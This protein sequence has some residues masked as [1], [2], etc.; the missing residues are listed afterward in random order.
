MIFTLRST[1]QQQ[2]NPNPKLFSS[3]FSIKNFIGLPPLRQSSTEIPKRIL[4]PRELSEQ[5]EAKM[6]EKYNIVKYKTLVERGM[7]ELEKKHKECIKNPE[8]HPMY[9]D[10]WKAFWSRRYKE[11][12]AQGKDANSY[13]YKPE[14]I[15]FWMK[16]MIELHEEDK[17]DKK[18]EIRRKL[19]L[20]VEFV[21]KIEMEPE[22]ARSPSKSPVRKISRSPIRRRSR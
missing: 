16:R 9:S 7:Q 4:T 13:N 12:I 20:T 3:N 22:K 21:N 17:K 10:E 8:K 14:W 1:L 19:K 15:T 6:L 2:I 18:N 5:S 11:L